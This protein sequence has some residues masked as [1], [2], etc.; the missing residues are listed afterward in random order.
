MPKIKPKCKI[1]GCTGMGRSH[2]RKRYMN[3]CGQHY[4]KFQKENKLKLT[5]QDN[6]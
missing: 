2:G 4:R 1:E 6:K 3:I 5:P